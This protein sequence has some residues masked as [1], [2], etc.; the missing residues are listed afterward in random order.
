[1]TATPFAA[2]LQQLNAAVLA[3]LPD[4]VALV[5]GAQVPVLFD[6]PYDA[7]FGAEADAS[8]PQ[9]VG[10][11]SALGQLARGDHITID[12]T[13]YVVERNEPDGTGLTRLVLYPQT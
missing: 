6:R 12:A 1:M 5:G 10:L 7:P 9:C 2:H 3:H 13:T 4:V 8:L 11:A